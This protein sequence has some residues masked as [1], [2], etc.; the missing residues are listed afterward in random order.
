MSVPL[1]NLAPN[2]TVS[3]LCFG[4]ATCALFS[5]C[6]CCHLLALQTELNPCLFSSGTMTF[7]EQNSLPESFRLLDEAFSAGVNFFDSAEMYTSLT[8]AIPFLGFFFFFFW[9][10]ASAYVRVICLYFLYTLFLC[11]LF[12]GFVL[13]RDINFWVCFTVFCMCMW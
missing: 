1:F 4:F 13:F 2:L 10:S 12:M 5:F 9:N 8:P 11:S 6:V 3:R 7:G